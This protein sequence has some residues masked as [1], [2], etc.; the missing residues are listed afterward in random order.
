MNVT[1]EPRIQPDAFESQA[2]RVIAA[3][4][5][6]FAQI[7]DALPGPADRATDVQKTLGIDRKLGWKVAR[8]VQDADP[9]AA[10][11][12]VPGKAAL[13]IFL[14]AAHDR[15]V[16]DALIEPARLAASEFEELARDHAGDRES[17]DMMLAG[18]ADTD[19]NATELNHRRL[20]FRGNSFICGVQ[21]RTQLTSL[22]V[23]P[24]ASDPHKLDVVGVTGFV[25]LRRVRPDAPIIISRNRA[26]DDDC[27]ARPT[28]HIESLDPD[29][30]PGAPLALI[31]EFCSRPLP[32]AREI[33][34]QGFVHLQIDGAGIGNHGAATY[35]TGVVYRGLLPRYADANNRYG[36][37]VAHV[38]TPARVLVHDMIVRRDTYGEIDPVVVCYAEHS[39]GAP[40]PARGRECGVV[41]MRTTVDRLGRG[42][43]CMRSSDVPRYPRLAQFVFNRMGWDDQAFDVHRARIEFA[44]VPTSV[45]M[46]FDLPDAP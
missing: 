32:Q 44:A 12:H 11:R 2:Q 18:L 20:A 42:A 45:V 43:S 13:E 35:F 29:V 46:R 27:N 23:S 16:S 6:S 36:E 34:E 24:A 1:T 25:Q 3:L 21:A 5:E 28:D 19:R 10:A 4:R 41:P 9:F 14:R 8:F 33:R 7:L 31:S 40:Y 15:G 22:Y 37:S 26:G 38:H 30:E 39:G 17:L